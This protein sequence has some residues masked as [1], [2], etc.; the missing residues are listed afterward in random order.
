ML[1]TTN[2]T[3][4]GARIAGTDFARPG[5]SVSG[6]RL[7]P[8]RGGAFRAQDFVPEEL[9]SRAGSVVLVASALSRPT[10]IVRSEYVIVFA[11][12]RRDRRGVRVV[13]DV[14]RDAMDASCII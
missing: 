7:E 2:A 8:P 10:L 5:K 3:A 14:G 13:T 4:E 6:F 1:C 9:I 11:L 12:S